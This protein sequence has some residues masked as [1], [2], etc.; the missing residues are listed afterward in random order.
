VFGSPTAKVT[1]VMAMEFACPFS[2]RTFG[3]VDQLRKQ[4]G[5]NL[6]V[7]YKTFVVHPKA[8]GAARAACAANKQGK[9]R[10][11]ADLLWTNAFEKRLTEPD[12]FSPASIE[13]L[14]RRAQLDIERYRRDVA[15]AC[16]LETHAEHLALGTG[17]EARGCSLG[18]AR[19]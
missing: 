10:E 11:M 17:A 2:Q 12:A 15:G 19:R 16:L 3:T 8:W 4:Y 5:D 14:P 9:W 6:R 7:V 1:L 18:T 13:E